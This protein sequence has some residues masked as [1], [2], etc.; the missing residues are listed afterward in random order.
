[1]IGRKDNVIVLKNGK[2]VYPEMIE[3]RL[4]QL[5]GQTHSIIFSKNGIELSAIIGFI[6]LKPNK[7]DMVIN[8]IKNLNNSLSAYEK[9]TK[10]YLT[11]DSFTPENGMLTST[12]KV[13]RKF[14]V[15]NYI[16]KEFIS[17]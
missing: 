2:K 13:K 15:A 11:T 16:N 12:F 6:F 17:L 5:E 4:G 3:K 1:V 9:I 7:R 10:V 8:Q 14:V